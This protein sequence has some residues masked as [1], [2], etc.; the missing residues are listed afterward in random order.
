[1]NPYQEPACSVSITQGV[2][3]DPLL[4][5]R[6]RVRRISTIG[7]RVGYLTFGVATGLLVVG[8]TTSFTQAIATAVVTLLI[9]GSVVLAPAILLHYAVRAADREDPRTG[10][11]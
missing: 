10:E 1:M 9:G 8:L 2:N 5:R 6:A 3:T 11:Q 4:A 7:R